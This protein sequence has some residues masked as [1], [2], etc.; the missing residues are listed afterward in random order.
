LS[1]RKIREVL[2]LK[3]E[4][5]ASDRDIAQAVGAARSTV[6]AALKRAREAGLAWPLPADLDDDALVA[7][8]YP[9]E[10]VAPPV[11]LPDWS[12]VHAE[13]RR[14]GVTRRLL[15][16]EYKARH[17][18]GY[19]YSAFCRDYDAWV[20]C[21]DPVLRFEHAPGERAYVDYAGL[22]MPL[23][24]RRTGAVHDAQVFTAVLGASG[25]T[26]VEA[27][28]GQTL[29]EW[30]GAHARAFDHFGGVPQVV[31]PDN[32]KSGV[33]RAC[34]Y[35][36]DLNP[37]YQDFAQHYR[38]AVLP[39]RVRK[40]RDKAKVEVGVQGIERWILAP[41]RHMTFFSLDQLNAA[42]WQR[43]EAYNDRPL[44]RQAGS[45]R[46]RFLKL[47]RPVLRPLPERRYVFATW[48][49]AKVH[50]DYHVE[51]ARTYY[52]VPYALIGRTVDVRVS[53]HV[54]DVFHKGRNVARHLRG[55]HGTRRFITDAAHRPE[56]HRAVVELSHDRL[57]ERAEA[58]GPSTA[59]LLREQVHRRVHPDEAL[60]SAL[61]ILRLAHDFSAIALEAACERA[62]RL[63]AYSYRAV[64]G[65][66]AQVD[67]DGA[68]RA[69]AP[70]PE[71]LALPLHGN[72][73]G[74][75]YFR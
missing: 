42:L 4:A 70:P 74:P 15:W 54:V 75:G 17:P 72:V 7:R 19:Q 32:L 37:T 59:A 25:Y 64:R 3:H 73:R 5:R 2:R 48:K 16:Q 35:E 47:D 20:G 22:T 60:R 62:L 52:S 38:L 36:P 56:R 58:I 65:L 27:S 30:L 66:I 67:E 46:S 53:E 39:A 63:R 29:P 26:Y 49:K 61:G 71:P 6:Q 40:P 51:V 14:K 23:T 34:R 24:D 8:L 44:S 50:L 10:V 13:L 11:P 28:L 31:V 9:R 68:S 33:T 43:L 57:L 1:V 55:G 69:P 21:Q 41:L 45:R 12:V 18:D